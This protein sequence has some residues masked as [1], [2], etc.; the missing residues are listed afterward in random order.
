MATVLIE[1]VLVV[2]VVIIY[3]GVEMMKVGGTQSRLPK[4]QHS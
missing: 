2:V 4:P 1:K 3:V